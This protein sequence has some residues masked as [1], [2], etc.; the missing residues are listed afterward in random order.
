VEA[1]K[2]LT[3]ELQQERANYAA[4]TIGSFFGNLLGDLDLLLSNVSLAGMNLRQR[5]DFLSFLLQKRPEVNIIALYDKQGKALPNLLAFDA[6]HILPSEL[7]LHQKKLYEA[8]RSRRCSDLNATGSVCF[9]NPYSV[10]RKP[11][12]ELGIE[13]RYEKVCALTIRVRGSDAE[14]VGMEVSLSF[15]S[16]VVS[17]LGGGGRSEVLL[18]D[19]DGAVIA[20]HTP[21]GKKSGDDGAKVEATTRYLA[22]TLGFTDQFSRFLPVSGARPVRLPDGKQMLAA[23]APVMAPGWIIVSMEPLELAYT[24]AKSMT[25]QVVTVVLVSVLVA[26][27]IGILFAFGITRPIS[28]CVSGAL[29][30]ARGNF[31]TVINISARN[32]IG[33]LAHTF[34]YMSEQLKYYDMQNR[35]L[36]ESLER[37]YLETIKALANS[38]DAKDPY[39]R[40][41]S[42]RVTNMAVEL[43]KRLGLDE[44]QLQ[45]LRYGGILHDIGKIGINESILAKK[46]SL[47]QEER[48]IIKNHPVLGEKIIAPIDFLAPVR[49]LVKHHHEWYDGTGYP[50]GLKGE[51]I[52]LGARIIGAADTYDAVTSDRPYQK[53][54]DNLQA[55]EILRNLRGKQID[56]TICDKLIEIIEE[57]IGEG[58]IHPAK[59]ATGAQKSN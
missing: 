20:R 32:E 10:Q 19:R 18:L 44:R 53:A 4:R 58:E 40:G 15:L 38:I 34:N 13:A 36:L 43:G 42:Q 52:P 48:Q 51:Q 17:E 21:S 1:V 16:D 22:K 33:E 35:Q 56:P 26:A 27:A 23:F 59:L 8:L 6:E 37:G 7:V 24:A 45:I 14:F 30:I 25:W 50:D 55:I 11:R 31:G 3:L 5:Q 12:R 57:R 54:V 2:T 39:T 46:E 41:H 9:S 49:P 29:A 28:K 47:T